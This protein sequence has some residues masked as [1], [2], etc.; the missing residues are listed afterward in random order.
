MVVVVMVIKVVVAPPYV[1]LR[2]KRIDRVIL[3]L[4][5]TNRCSQVGG[6]GISLFPS[7]NERYDEALR[8]PPSPPPR[9]EFWKS[10]PQSEACKP[11][12]LT[13]ALYEP[14]DKIWLPLHR[15]YH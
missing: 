8:T 10:T 9:Q 13:Y 11:H 3:I 4:P 1:L 12:V 6:F 14:C 7:Q 15:V 5:P 2:N